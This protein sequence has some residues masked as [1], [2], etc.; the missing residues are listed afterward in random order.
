MVVFLFSDFRL[1]GSQ[2][3]AIDIFNSLNKIK[4]NSKILT[5]QNEGILK[6]YIKSKNTI[7][8]LKSNRALSSISTLYNYLSKNKP[9]KVFCTQPHLGILVFIVNIFLIKKVKIIVRETNTSSYESFFDV[10]LKKRF[11]NFLKKLLFNYINCVIFPSKE[12]S[13]NLKSKNI[14]IPNFVDLSEIKKEKKSLKKNYI[15]AMGRLTKQK[16]FDILINAFL[17][18]NKKVK[19]NLFIFGE[20]EEKKNLINLIKKNNAESRIK[21]LNFTNKTYSY[22]K[23]CD[24]FILSSRWEGMPNIL[25]QALSCRSNILSTDCKFGPKQILKNGK[26]GYLCKV[27]DV[28]S[29][30]KKIIDALK[31][32]KKITYNDIVKYDKKKII[33]QYL[34]IFI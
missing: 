3:V 24:L 23:S 32:K 1:G 9:D 22:L 8:S 7:S 5:I 15:L 25:I 29:M 34:K 21:I 18:I 28:N 30:S 17:K 33:A 13:Y 11:E 26:L 14:I 6:K 16:G 20:G 19:Q 27:N 4:P 2:K 31:K 12:I 10:S